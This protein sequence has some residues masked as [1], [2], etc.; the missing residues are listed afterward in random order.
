MKFFLC[1]ILIVF[2]LSKGM[3]AACCGGGTSFPSLIT[4]DFRSQLN[5][6]IGRSKLLGKKLSHQKKTKWSSPQKNK[7][8]KVTLEVAHLFDNFYQIGITF[9][10]FFKQDHTQKTSQTA[11]NIGDIEVTGGYEFLPE[12]SYSLWIP[13]GILFTKVTFPTG[14][15]IYDSD[16]VKTIEITGSGVYKLTLGLG[17]LK[18]Q[19][20]W[21]AQF[22]VEAH[23]SFQR[24][25]LNNTLKVGPGYG[26]SALLAVG[27]NPGNSP[28]RWGVSLAPHYEAAKTLTYNKKSIGS[29][30]ETYWDASFNASYLYSEK[31]AFNFSITD[32]TLFGPAHNTTL[33]R[34][35]SVGVQKRWPL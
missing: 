11:Q 30:Y 5:F 22:L 29:D 23:Q 19:G 8:Q 24:S 25:F 16:T 2:P 6:T 13:R 28:W 12:M 15:S 32:Q 33:S 7:S 21:D 17:L 14:K 4:G 18:V 27:L 35:F 31:T 9:P 1:F 3:C 20:P 10:Y 26:V 34:A